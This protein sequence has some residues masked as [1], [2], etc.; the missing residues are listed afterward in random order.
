MKL[1]SSSVEE[2]T[3]EKFKEKCKELFKQRFYMVSSRGKYYDSL[4]IDL[5]DIKKIYNKN[6][7]FGF[8]FYLL[9]KDTSNERLIL[10]RDTHT[11]VYTLTD[12][13]NFLEDIFIFRNFV[14]KSGLVI[15]IGKLS[16]SNP[17]INF[18]NSYCEYISLDSKNINYTDI[19]SLFYDEETK[20]GMFKTI[21]GEEYMFKLVS[22]NNTFNVDNNMKTA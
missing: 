6:D 10:K 8:K 1:V 17:K 9:D 16:F 18:I 19:V 5:F 3:F 15:A 14:T 2:L 12:N 20:C 21:D 4:Y 7:P 11:L 22:E 13:N